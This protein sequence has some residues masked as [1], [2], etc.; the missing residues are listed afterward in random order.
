MGRRSREH[1]EAYGKHNPEMAQYYKPEE[2]TDEAGWALVADDVWAKAMRLAELIGTTLS[3]NSAYRSPYYNRVVLIAR[4]LG[5][6]GS[7]NYTASQLQAN[8]GGV[9]WNS[10][11][12][13]GVALDVTG[14]SLS[15]L[16]TKAKEVGFVKT[17]RYSS[18]VHMDTRVRRR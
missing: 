16:E 9:A 1:Y 8:R 4:K 12:M 7:K 3:I 5:F 6:D 2:N 11:H 17:I 18:F 13:D 15:T 10:Y 14:A